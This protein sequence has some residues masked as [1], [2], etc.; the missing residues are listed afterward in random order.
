[1]LTLFLRIEITGN[2]DKKSEHARADDIG[3]VDTTIVDSQSLSNTRKFD[4]KKDLASA[5]NEEA[6]LHLPE[7]DHERHKP[8]EESIAKLKEQL[9]LAELGCSR[10]QAQFQVY[11]LRW[12][13]ECHRARILEEYAPIGINTCPPRQI[14]WDAPSPIQSTSDAA[15]P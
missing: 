15:V 14:Q 4:V 3:C 5:E 9:R 11:R 2:V 10:L 1:V 6:P 7:C 8:E 13:E 12:L